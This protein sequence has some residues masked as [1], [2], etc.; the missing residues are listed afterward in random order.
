MFWWF[1]RQLWL[2]NRILNATMND[3]EQTQ[4]Q[5][6]DQEK[7]AA[8]GQLVASVAHEINTP[9]GA[10]KT[11][12][13]NISKAVTESLAELPQLNQY[14][15]ESEQKLFFSLMKNA[16]NNYSPMLSSEKRALKRKLTKELKEYEIENYRKIA[17]L[18]IDIGIYE[19]VSPFLPLLQ[20]SQV[21][22][23]LQ[24]LYNLTRLVNNNL[25][26]ITSVE[27]AS[28]I[29][30]ALK[31]YA[32]QDIIGE[33]ELANITDGIETA[34]EIYHNQIKHDIKVIR[35]YQAIPQIW[36]YPDE[37]IQ[38][39]T[40]LIHNAIQAMEQQ[41]TLIIVIEPDNGM[42]KVQITDSGCGIPLELQD[43]ILTPFF[44]TK[45]MGEGSGLGLH[46]SEKIITKHQGDLALTS[47]PGKTTITV[48]LP[49]DPTEIN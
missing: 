13:S 38:V 43:K 14:L 37:L 35:E 4:N 3:L 6:I 24:L 16:I 19:E 30:F 46:I 20:H 49:I 48:R 22:W 11:S 15:D 40:N 42:V 10:I 28:K 5:L 36:C 1:N 18:L 27:R 26:T 7:M 9:L 31:N 41:G 23:I 47:Q 39:W 29:V 2:K 34:L 33:K 44:T 21:N 17:D 12:A 25:T 8:L 32:R 45:P